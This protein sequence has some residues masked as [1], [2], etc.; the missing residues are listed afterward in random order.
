MYS[1]M[2]YILQVNTRDLRCEYY[3]DFAAQVRRLRCI[4]LRGWKRGK[5]TG[6]ARASTTGRENKEL[7]TSDRA[8][9]AAH[10]INVDC[11]GDAQETNMFKIRRALR[12]GRRTASGLANARIACKK[13]L[14]IDERTYKGNEWPY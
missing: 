10:I 6:S 1:C 9:L 13:Q 3:W 5:T 14:A 2:Q 11:T 12:L 4:P 8:A 7:T